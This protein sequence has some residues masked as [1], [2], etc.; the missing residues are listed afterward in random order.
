MKHA[1]SVELSTTCRLIKKRDLCKIYGTNPRIT[2]QMIRDGIIPEPIRLGSS[3]QSRRWLLETI[4]QH[5]R[6]LATA[7]QA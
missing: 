5:L 2:E 6:G 4:E 7:E 1:T 3:P